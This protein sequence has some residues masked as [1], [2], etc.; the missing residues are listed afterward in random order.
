MN[1]PRPKN[2]GSSVL[3][4]TKRD[5][6]VV[7]FCKHP[8]L[9]RPGCPPALWLQAHASEQTADGRQQETPSPHISG[10]CSERLGVRFNLY[11]ITVSISFPMFFSI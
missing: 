3:L 4:A 6:K 2:E 7:C 8:V 5:C 1:G 11:M 9:S 10:R